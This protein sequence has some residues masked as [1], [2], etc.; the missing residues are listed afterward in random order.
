LGRPA[1]VGL[2]V[3]ILLMPRHEGVR[4][5]LRNFGVFE[6]PLQVVERVHI[7]NLTGV[8]EAHKEIPDIGTA[9]GLVEEGVFAVYE[10]EPKYGPIFERFKV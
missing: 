4:G 8:D 7:R 2:A 6:Q 10:V 5:G 3:L 1:G 9:L